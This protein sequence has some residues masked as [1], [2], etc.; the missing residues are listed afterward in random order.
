MEVR[1]PADIVNLIVQ[2]RR[3]RGLTQVELS[4]RAGVSRAWLASVEAGKP[5][6]DAG[7]ILRTLAALGIL[8]T[9]EANVR[10]TGRRKA[11]KARHA[12]P[13]DIDKI[14]EAAR[15]RTAHG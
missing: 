2:A 4:R 7:L 3:T 8:L 10:R 12:T 9:A 6:M 13:V 15:R 14:V 1:T 5:R 11:T